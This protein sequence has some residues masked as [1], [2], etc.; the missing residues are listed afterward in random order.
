[1]KKFS[2]LFLVIYVSGFSQNVNKIDIGGII[3]E[4]GSGQKIE[5]ACLQLL[6][7]TQG[8]IAYGA[9]TDSSGS[10]FIPGV[11][12]QN[13]K[14]VVS[15]IG[16]KTYKQLLTVSP[17]KSPFSLSVQLILDSVYLHET[18]IKGTATGTKTLVDKIVF[19]PD[20]TVLKDAMT[21]LDVIRKAPDVTVNKSTNEVKVLGNP[22]VLILIDGMENNRDLR[23]IDSKDIERVEIITNPSSKYDSDV[24]TVLN[25]ILRKDRKKGLKILTTLD[26]FTQKKHYDGNISV[27][28]SISKFRIFGSVNLR[29]NLITTSNF[30]DERETES[31]GSIFRYINYSGNL[32]NYKFT[33]ELFKYGLDFYP[34]SRTLINFTGSYGKYRNDINENLQNIYLMD[35][36]TLYTA[37]TYY[38]SSGTNTLQNYTLYFKQKF[39]KK[40]DDNE[41][42]C[43]TNIYNMQKA[44]SL[45]QQ[46][47]F[48][49]PTDTLSANR[50]TLSHYS[51]SSVN[52][53]L[54]YTF[55]LYKLFNIGVGGQYYERNIRNLFTVN[56]ITQNFNYYDVRKAFYF[57]S[58]FRYKKISAQ[59]GVRCENYRI[60]Y[61]TVK[62]GQLNLMP[63]LSV[64]LNFHKKGTIKVT[65][66]NSLTYPDYYN[67]SPFIYYSN[68][69]LTVSSGSPNLK[70]EKTNSF[71]LNYS[72]RRKSKFVSTSLL[73]KRIDNLIGET[74]A[75][76]GHTLI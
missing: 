38:N 6:E 44:S 26:F 40:D 28:Y 34:W 37:H 11:K 21:G 76:N 35:D 65:Y 53:K 32:H 43:N 49:Y 47:C 4:K 31:G 30:R 66:K 62:F 68:D 41:I 58:V 74:T 7:T 56:N 73:L 57:T 16:Y 25:V 19:V 23:S 8:N 67:L 71:E 45:I 64:M 36:S 18:V 29:E 9:V 2:F 54:D 13:Y 15:R 52:T 42:T 55:P 46:T 48:Y 50:T 70:P 75:L 39:G 61:D 1:M 51:L 3:K 72:I 63:T 24:A 60:H 14:L 12:C 17:T 69:S 33:G 20:S 22:N 5:Y 27:D 59:V 10:F